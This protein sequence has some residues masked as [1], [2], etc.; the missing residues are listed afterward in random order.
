[1]E[2]KELFERLKEG[3]GF[4]LEFKNGRYNG[5]AKMRLS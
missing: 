3:G 2:A 4:E 5:L 1:M